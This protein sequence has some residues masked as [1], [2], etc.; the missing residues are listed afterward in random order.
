MYAVIKTGGKQYRVQEGDLL[1]IEKLD[2]EV[3]KKVTFDDVLMFGEGAEI[4][5]GADA[6]KAKVS[7]VVTD[8][9]RGQKIVIF[10]KR[11]RKHSQLTKGHRQ[12]YTQVR[13]TEVAATGAA[14][15]KAAPKA[16]AKPAAA[17]KAAPKA[18]AKPAAKKAA[19]P[20]KEAAAKKPAAKKAAA[21]KKEA[22]AKKPAAKKAAP[23]AEAKPAA[24][25]TAAKAKKAS[26][27]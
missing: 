13:I 8:A 17:K 23:K 3:G 7:A 21:P 16:E 15:K 22:A 19:A 1:R 10:K 20:K 24:K 12:D 14:A 11:R 2:A 27:E 5:T 4:K 9:G 18:E 25:K 26:E 6:A